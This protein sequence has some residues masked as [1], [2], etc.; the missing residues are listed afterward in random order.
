MGINEKEL[1]LLLL[2][3]LLIMIMSFSDKKNHNK[4]RLKRR[5]IVHVIKMKIP[6]EPLFSMIKMISYQYYF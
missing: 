5:I 4:L 1:V 6:L 3:N 2:R